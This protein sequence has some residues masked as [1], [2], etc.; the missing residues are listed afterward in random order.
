M[1]RNRVTY[2]H[3]LFLT[4]S[5][6][7]FVKFTTAPACEAPTNFIIIGVFFAAAHRRHQSGHVGVTEVL[8]LLDQRGIHSRAATM[9][10]AGIRLQAVHNNDCGP[11]KLATETSWLPLYPSIMGAHETLTPTPLNSFNDGFNSPAPAISFPG[12]VPLS[13]SSSSSFFGYMV[14]LLLVIKLRERVARV[15]PSMKWRG[16]E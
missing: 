13:A 1:H 7:H 11:R 2:S 15:F 5:T 16:A 6:A 4:P 3:H 12:S 14:P 10:I 8:D 9:L